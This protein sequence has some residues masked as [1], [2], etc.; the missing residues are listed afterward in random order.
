MSDILELKK[1]GPMAV[2]NELFANADDMLCMLDDKGFFVKTSASWTRE[3]GWSE[4]ELCS[5]PWTEILHPDD[6][7]K[8]LRC[9]EEVT[10]SGKLTSGFI[11]R[12]RCKDGSYKSLEW[13]LP[14]M[15]GTAVFSRCHVIND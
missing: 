15:V 5:K 6:L 8:T 2:L 1:F 3:M 13:S 7:E 9:Y 14:G 11:N 4:E 12:Y 10:K